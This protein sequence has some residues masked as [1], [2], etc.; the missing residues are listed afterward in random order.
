LFC[1]GT[2]T[3]LNHTNVSKAFTTLLTTAGIRA[4]PKPR[5]YDLRH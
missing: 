4:E 1:S 2:G 5:L 3:R